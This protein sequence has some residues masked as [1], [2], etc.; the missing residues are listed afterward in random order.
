M[1]HENELTTEIDLLFRNLDGTGTLLAEILS[2]SV[3]SAVAAM[4]LK[5]QG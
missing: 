4:R 3:D 5:E 2:R 1:T